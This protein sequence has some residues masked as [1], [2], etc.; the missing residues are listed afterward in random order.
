MY[1][2]VKLERIGLPNRERLDV[3]GKP[4]N[5][6]PWVARL[7][8][9]DGKRF[10][11]EFLKPRISYAH[12]NSQ[13][14]RGVYYE[15]FISVAPGEAY[16]LWSRESWSRTHRRYAHFDGGKEVKISWDE[17]YRRAKNHSAS[18]S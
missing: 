3:I 12:A 14:T 5:N 1:A 13:G 2:Y 15:W 9:C 7:T 4:P 11:R 16:E 17:A 10:S 8:G 6:N 18:T